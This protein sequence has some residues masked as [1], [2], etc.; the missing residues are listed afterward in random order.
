[1]YIVRNFYRDR[2]GYRCLQEAVRANYLKHYDATPEP[3]P[4]VFV[5]LTKGD[6]AAPGFACV[7]ITYGDSG[8]LFSEYYL[9]E[10][11]DRT[12]AIDRAR[13]VEVGAFASFHSGSGAGRY[14]L[15]TVVKTLALHNYGL[16]VL[17]ATE[18]VRQILGHIVTNLDDL[19]DAQVSRVK[20]PHVNWGSYYAHAPRVVASRLTS[21]G[22]WAHKPCTLVRPK[23]FAL[24]ASA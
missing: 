6:G 9:E 21:P 17:T 5:C 1:M 24:P 7:G 11:L 15:K 3:R 8:K 4:D 19:G 22:A 20:D 10:P 2:P 13:I 23:T 12:Y 18:Q 16:M 14:L